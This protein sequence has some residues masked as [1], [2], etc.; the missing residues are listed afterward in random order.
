MYKI[1]FTNK[2]KKD[3]KTV[4]KRKYD[5]QLLR[6]V[7]QLLSHTGELPKQYYPH[8]LSG[9]YSDYWECHIKPDWLLIWTIDHDNLEIWLTRTGTH[10]DLF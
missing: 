3:Y 8:K 2:F 1:Y 9:V 6:E 7:T 4:I 10:S 5:L